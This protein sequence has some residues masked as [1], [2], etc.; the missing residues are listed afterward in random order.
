[1]PDRS[2]LRIPV[3][4]MSCAACVRRVE[5]ALLSVDGVTEAS[6][7][8]ATG[9]ATVTFDP[10][11][12]GTP[13]L[14]QAIESAGYGTQNER[15]E[16]EVE[17][18][19]CASCVQRIERNLGNLPGVLSAS[20][21]LATGVVT[22]DA[23]EGTAGFDDVVDAASR[24]GDYRVVPRRSNRGLDAAA[25]AGREAPLRSGGG[26]PPEDAVRPRDRESERLL[27]DLVVAGVLTILV[28]VGSM[29]ALFPFVRSVPA[30]VRNL[31]L[32]VLTTPVMFWA[33]A[34]FF[35]GF[36]SAARHR[37]ADMN[38]LVAVG[39]S[40]A[41]VYSTV[42]SFAPGLLAT[43]AADVHVYFDTSAMII[44]LILLGRFLERRARGRAS[45][46]IR[47]LAELAPR[48]ARVVRA[49]GEVEVPIDRVSPGDVVRVRPGEKVPV[50]GRIV[51]GQ[52]AVDESM[53]TGESVPVDKGPGDD[54]TGATIVR[55]G[56]FDF[57]ATR[58]GRETVLAR[59]IRMVE[60]AQ[61]SKAPIQRLADRV[62]AV[63]VP[64]V[65]GLAA[66]T[67]VVWILLGPAPVLTNALLRTVA[68]LIIACPC[69]MGLATPT[70]IMVGTGRG[71][72]TGIFIKGGETLETAHRLTAVVLDKTGTLTRGEMSCTDVEPVRGIEEEELLRAAA[73]VELG[74]EHPVAQAVVAK[75]RERGLILPEVEGFEA[76]PGKGVRGIVDGRLVL[77]GT[78][79]FLA[80]GGVRRMAD[81]E[82]SE[83]REKAQRGDV[84]ASAAAYDVAH[85]LAARGTTPL[86]VS[87]DGA[88]LGALGV[89]DTLRPESA[90][91]VSSLK[92]MGLTVIM[93]TGDREAVAHAVGE[94]VGVDRVIAEVLP[95]DKAAE[96]RR[97]QEEGALVAMVGDGIN[98]A[99][100]LAQAD[101]GIAIGTGTDVAME[102]SDI[103]LMRADLTGVVQAIRL[104]RR[105][106]RT[107]R[108]N[109]F[110]AFFYNVVGIPVAAGA[111]YPAFGVLLRPVFAA[112]AM[113]FS[114]VSVVTNSL[115]LRRARL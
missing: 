18:I 14:A 51:S 102:A 74:S 80:E 81:A 30:E 75:A 52:S 40:A 113:A 67:F 33:G 105:T 27:R 70:A 114:S 23:L 16:A 25:P 108:Q 71:A 73:A 65:I 4:G 6:V 21:N 83:A 78:E 64:T 19:F 98:D 9:I 49:E 3:T 41:Y 13:E 46:A 100:A 31:A 58:T 55:T 34:R 62:A 59:I 94:S 92:E 103:T 39:T 61:G 110:W 63:F 112:A 43:T 66:I 53:I 76:V 29:P 8:L 93:L 96:I 82:P 106:I 26:F 11:S 56:S 57:E 20:V 5:K 72:E 111:L 90:A 45:Q 28:F 38:T 42:A 109:L 86:I 10:S 48:T 36:W 17:G 107:I 89:A 22:V 54:V 68:V 47:R 69:A 115:R 2:Q 37:T 95:G 91:A 84:D 50:D 77:V 88:V 1:M 15:I 44:T 32:F 79:G 7:N 85:S 60:D 87:R 35:R 12:T 99:P 104:S 24:A 101:V 97:L